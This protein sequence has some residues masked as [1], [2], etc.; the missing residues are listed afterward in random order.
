MAGLNES[1]AALFRLAQTLTRCAGRFVRRNA[2]KI[3]GLVLLEGML[4]LA[5]LSRRK[6]TPVLFDCGPTARFPSV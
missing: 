6:F 4:F 1:R 5:R 2:R 3:G